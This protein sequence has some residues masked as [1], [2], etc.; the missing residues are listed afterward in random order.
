MAIK[1]KVVAGVGTVTADVTGTVKA[2][3]TGGP[4]GAYHFE[5]ANGPVNLTIAGIGRGQVFAPRALADVE[6][7]VAALNAA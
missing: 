2:V 1:N 6:A 7:I 4:S 3:Q 5:D